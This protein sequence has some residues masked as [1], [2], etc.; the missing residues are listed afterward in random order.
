MGVVKKGWDVSTKYALYLILLLS[1]LIEVI[2]HSKLEISFQ[3]HYHKRRYCQDPRAFLP[4]H[5][6]SPRNRLPATTAMVGVGTV[7]LQSRLAYLIRVKA[8]VWADLN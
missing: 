1:R 8:W 6:C 4:I 3:V 2:L 5:S 7:G